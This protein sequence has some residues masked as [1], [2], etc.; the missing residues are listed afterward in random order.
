MSTDVIDKSSFHLRLPRARVIVA[1]VRRDF[2]VTRSYRLAFVSD[3]FSGLVGL[4]VYYFISELFGEFTPNDLQGAPTYFAFAAV[5][6]ILSAVIYAASAGISDQLRVE[7]LTGTLEALATHPINPS[8]MCI[9]F[10]GFPLLFALL[11]SLLYLLVGATW[12]DVDLEQMSWLGVFIVLLSAGFALSS[13]GILSAG[14]VLIIKRGDALAAL[15]IVGMTL[16][17]GSVFPISAMPEWL[18]TIG[19]VMPLRFAFDGVRTALFEGEGWTVDAAALAGFGAIT[20]PMS[21]FFFSFALT[22]AKR[23]GSLS[24]Y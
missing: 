13:L 17:S 4:A 7:Q 20:L 9:G 12:M 24:Q 3:A 23:A 19:Q 6:A 1:V 10:T 21:V 16:L 5:G 15:A 2:A 8:E 18:E 11:R 22:H 14:A